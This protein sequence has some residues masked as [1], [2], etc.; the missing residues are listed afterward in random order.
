M[1]TDL[2]SKSHFDLALDVLEQGR[3]LETQSSWDDNGETPRPDRIVELR[4]R[5]DHARDIPGARRVLQRR[6]IDHR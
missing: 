3:A 4:H 2:P 6:I 5:V 1:L